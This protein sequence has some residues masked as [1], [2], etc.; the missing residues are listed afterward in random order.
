MVVN[1]IET[2][3]YG[4]VAVYQFI[5]GECLMFPVKEMI[6]IDSGIVIGLPGEFKNT[7]K[8]FLSRLI[9]MQRYFV[10]F[11]NENI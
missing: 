4:C 11:K 6:C 2:A 10:G 5:E 3:P 8:D 1:H 9:Y 7:D